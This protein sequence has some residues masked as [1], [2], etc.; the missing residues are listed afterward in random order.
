MRLHRF[1]Y[2]GY[3]RFV[4]TA[5]ELAGVPC[6]IVDVPFGDRNDLAILT[7]GYI[8]VPVLVTDAGDVL[9]DSRR[10]VA[11]LVRDDARFAGLVPVAD[12]GPIWA[13][14]DWAGSGLEDVAFRIASPALRHRLPTAHERA[15]FV[16]IKE[17]KFGPGCVDQWKRDADSLFDRLL[18]L[19]EPTVATLAARPFLF[20][21]TPTAADAALHGQLVMLDF[22]APA[23]V[24]ALPPVLLAW[25]HRLEARMGPPPYGRPAR[26]HRPTTAIES[27]L[28]TA[29]AAPRTAAVELIVVRTKM[30]ERATPAAIALAPGRGL[31]GDRWAPK[32]VG[33]DDEV[34]LM[35][36][37]VAAAVAHREDWPLFGDN[38]FVDLPI[39]ESDL[40]PGD[41][42]AI[43]EVVLEITAHPHLGCR[44]LMARFGP[45][46]LRWINAKP[47]RALRRRGVYARIVTGG[48]IQR[49][50]SVR[51]VS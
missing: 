25:K 19:L 40:R 10:I 33:T 15:L 1:E 18:E 24:A 30:H 27:A 16:F 35:D 28:A 48:T 45:D 2:S 34:S 5:I 6:E 39:G 7:G 51:V 43:G 26:E 23:R 49:G 47:D 11:T 36:V 42:L 38:L 14:V 37:R 44:K 4:Q 41:R 13:Y 17:R 22:G 46:A 12:A 32:L 3:A 20:G 9:T 50:D 21:A 31:D 29:S 8:Q